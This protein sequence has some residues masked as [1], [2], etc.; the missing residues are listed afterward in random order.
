MGAFKAIGSFLYLIGLVVALAGFLIMFSGIMSSVS[1]T[2]ADAK[3]ASAEP[4][5]LSPQCQNPPCGAQEEGMDAVSAVLVGGPVGWLVEDFFTA[6]GLSE[7]ASDPAS[8]TLYVRI[9][10][11]FA[12]LIVGLSLV[13]I[14]TIL[15]MFDE[16]ARQ[17]DERGQ[18]QAQAENQRH[19]VGAGK[20]EKNWVQ[21]Y[22]GKK[23]A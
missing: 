9:K 17:I 10:V 14:G 7:M 11:F 22:A 16:V 20:P 1:K 23:D 15:R 8:A 13:L 5:A 3:A 6:I 19:R 2:M 18:R 21:Y 12:Y 4:S